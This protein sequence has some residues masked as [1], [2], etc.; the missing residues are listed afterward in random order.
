MRRW[1]GP[2]D[3]LVQQ[4]AW[5]L[6]VLAAARG[7]PAV[8]G[9]AGAGAVGL[10]LVLRPGERRRVAAVAAAAAAFGLLTDSLLVAAGLVAFGG[11]GATSPAWMVGLWGAFGA[12]LTASLRALAA[13]PAPRLAALAALAGPFAYRAGAALGAIAFPDGAGAALAAVA[14]QWA[15]GVPLLALAARRAAPPDGR[16][17]AGLAAPAAGRARW[18]WA[19]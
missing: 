12:G 5:W 1:L 4:A 18:R 8:A 14:L 3:A 10:H 11:G 16:P 9:L 17:G 2:A 13:W 7:A 6:A 19:R 15:V